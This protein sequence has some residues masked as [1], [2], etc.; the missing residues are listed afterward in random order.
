MAGILDLFGV[1][2]QSPIPTNM[3]PADYDYSQGILA[4]AMGPPKSAMMP[5]APQID[6]M[7]KFAGALTAFGKG[8]SIAGSR[9]PLETF[10]QIQSADTA[11]RRMS[12][13]ELR[14]RRPN[15]T[16]T[17][18]PGVFLAVYPD[19]RQETV[20][21]QEA[22]DAAANVEDRR[23]QRQ[24]AQFNQQ[25]TLQD[26]RLSQMLQIASM[27]NEKPKVLPA[28]LQKVE[29]EYEDAINAHVNNVNSIRPVIDNLTPN[30][31]TGKA[32]LE[33]GPLK[34]AY[35]SSR[36]LFGRSTPESLR[37][38]ELEESKTRFVNESLRLN[39]GVQTEGDAQ[40]AAKELEAAWAK[41]DTE[42]S[43]KAFERL[44]EVNVRAANN[45]AGLINKQRAAQGV[46]PLY[47]GPVISGRNKAPST[48]APGTTST[49]VKFTIE[50]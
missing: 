3:T 20:V 35:N 25:N 41:N 45:K 19:G 44:E 28:G 13:D 38:Q 24:Q 2:G 9:N 50:R 40:R 32:P 34:N 36:N 18:Q 42:A 5:Q 12:L 15:M 10:S 29:N 7:D 8:L 6:P 21:V 11:A 1:G 39:K 46:E 37:Y 47:S 26:Q 48:P 49:G 33:L 14:A 43:R 16:P 17:G 4:S 31:E 23:D 22:V 30:P 27:K